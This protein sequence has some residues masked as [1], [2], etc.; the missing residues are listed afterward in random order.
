[1]RL[2]FGDMTKEV[3]VFNL[4]K[5]SRK[6]KDQTFEVNFIENICE[7][8]SE[9]ESLFLD[10]LFEDKCD[11]INE[12]THVGDPNFRVPFKKKKFDLSV[13]TV[14]EPIN[15]ISHENIIQEPSI[16]LTFENLFE[17][18]LLCLDEPIRDILVNYTLS[19]ESVDL[20]FKEMYGTELEFLSI[21][22][23]KVPT[24][25]CD[26]SHFLNNGCGHMRKQSLRKKRLGRNK[27]K[28]KTLASPLSPIKR[29]HWN[30][31]KRA[32]GMNPKKI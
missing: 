7:K 20:S 27:A 13:F 25:R 21:H 23:E 5:Q 19:G 3:N 6:I 15:D 28:M 1:M 10:E 18:E 32:R 12:K 24:K 11:Y 17:E 16:D 8:E 14:D 9:N 4:E 26:G 2:T 29:T 22:S 30:D 31:G